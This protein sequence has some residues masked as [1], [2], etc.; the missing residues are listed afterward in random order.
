MPSSSS[1]LREDA[2]EAAARGHLPSLYDSSAVAM[3]ATEEE[4]A[5]RRAN[6]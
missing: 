2:A 3:A 6:L 1:S 4:E 5:R